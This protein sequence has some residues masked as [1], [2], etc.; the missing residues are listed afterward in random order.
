MKFSGESLFNDGV[1]VVVF[2]TIYEVITAGIQN[3]SVGEIA[4]LFLKDAGGG[5]NLAYC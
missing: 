2:I 1:A 5:I 3:I 4:W